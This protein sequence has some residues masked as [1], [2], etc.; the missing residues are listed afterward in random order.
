MTLTRVAPCIVVALVA[1]ACDRREPAVFGR[2]CVDDSDCDVPAGLVCDVVRHQCSPPR[3]VDP[4]PGLTCDDAHALE[5]REVGGLLTGSLDVELGA[6]ATV[7]ADGAT[8]AGDDARWVYARVAV[9]APMA[10]R[11]VAT[12]QGKVNVAVLD[13]ACT[14]A[15]LDHGCSA[16]NELTLPLLEGTVTIAVSASAGARVSLAVEQLR[17][18]AGFLPTATG[19][20]GFLDVEGPIAR[21]D[22]QLV[23][24]DGDGVVASGGA[25]TDGAPVLSQLFSRRAL[26]WRDLLDG[27][28][29]VGHA[30]AA[31]QGFFFAVGGAGE[32]DPPGEVLDPGSTRFFNLN[33]P[34]EAREIEGGSLTPMSEDAPL[35]FVGGQTPV[36]A[37]F[38]SPPSSCDESFDCPVSFECVAVLEGGFDEE[39]EGVCVCV[40]EDCNRLVRE[41]PS[42]VTLDA[43]ADLRFRRRHVALDVEDG[44]DGALVL[45]TGGVVDNPFDPDDNPSD[46]S[47]DPPASFVMFEESLTFVQVP[48][49]PTPRRDAI[50]VAVGSGDVLIVGGRTVDDAGVE[51]AT[52]LIELWTPLLTQAPG[53]TRLARPRADF[54][55]GLLDGSSAQPSSATTFAVIGGDDGNGPLATS[56]LVD[57]ATGLARVGP[58]LPYP[59]SGARAALLETGEMLVVGGRTVDGALVERALLLVEVGPTLVKPDVGTG[60]NLPEVQGDFCEE[61]VL[62]EGDNG[63]IE[64]NTIGFQD[65]LNL[66]NDFGCNGVTTSR[67]IDV[68]FRL[69]VPAGATVDFTLIDPVGAADLVLAVYDSCPATF[70]CLDGADLEIEAAE[71]LSVT[72]SEARSLNILVDGFIEDAPYNYRLDW[73]VTP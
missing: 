29:R 70:P 44:S 3:P 67:G 71:V 28:G 42:W 17:C 19:C 63:S 23:V 72:V 68:F 43:P 47:V 73:R 26:R 25:A 66:A 60:F 35:L 45:V 48:V 64:G 61:A 51:A 46:G 12:G 9:P 7:S 24:I 59:L 58:A 57:V 13:D 38:F 33:E 53:A 55:G 15:A 69:D 20:L 8:C 21:T 49:E 56:E 41:N 5:L 40:A 62:L 2:D 31:T 11:I 32:D 18:P 52:D 65:D 4:I 39:L 36:A 10:A 54:A 1:S 22:H 34:T 14:G 16:D 37:L 6:D 30:A 50:A 27:V